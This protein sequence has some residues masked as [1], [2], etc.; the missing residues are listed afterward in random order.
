MCDTHRNTKGTARAL[1]QEH[2]CISDA[3]ALSTHGSLMK[4]PPDR[5]Q[6][7]E[8]L[9]G[10]ERQ[11]RYGLLTSVW[12]EIKSKV[13][14]GIFWR[15]PLSRIQRR[16]RCRASTG[17][18]IWWPSLRMYMSQPATRASVTGTPMDATGEPQR[19]Q[20][21]PIPR[22]TTCLERSALGLSGLC[23]QAQLGNQLFST[24]T[25]PFCHPVLHNP[26]QP[27]KPLQCSSG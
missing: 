3:H 7:Y 18:T 22:N 16:R 20:P 13:V 14:R 10:Q 5:S 17:G 8:H 26:N 23:N 6:T 24:A 21:A 15:R 11:Y 19:V 4:S 27:C 12:R 9:E 2:E 1:G 25:M